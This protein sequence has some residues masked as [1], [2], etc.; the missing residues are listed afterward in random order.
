[1]QF[2]K[3]DKKNATFLLLCKDTV[4]SVSPQTATHVA[5]GALF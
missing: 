3:S 2:H 1:M 5:P 4:L